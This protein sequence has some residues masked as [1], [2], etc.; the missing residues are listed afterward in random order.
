MRCT[1]VRFRIA[2]SVKPLWLPLH[3]KLLQLLLFQLYLSPFPHSS[4]PLPLT[5]SLSP[6][7]HT[8]SSC[9][10]TGN[11]DSMVTHHHHMGRWNIPALTDVQNRSRV[12]LL[13]SKLS[14]D[15]LHNKHS[16]HCLVYCLDR[17]RHVTYTSIARIHR[18]H[19]SVSC[20]LVMIEY[21]TCSTYN[22][23]EYLT[24]RLHLEMLLGRGQ[25]WRKKK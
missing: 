22:H 14:R 8:C 6:L 24:A 23:V 20:V 25:F 3:Q 16:S 15:N 4:I 1:T 18:K 19:C 2:H 13:R 9:V 7:P 10:S 5:S 11:I 17:V 12:R 21:S